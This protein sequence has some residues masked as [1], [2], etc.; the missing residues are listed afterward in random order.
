MLRSAK[1]TRPGRP[2]PRADPPRAGHDAS[3]YR[4]RL[5]RESTPHLGGV[6][7]RLRGPHVSRLAGR[8]PRRDEGPERDSTGRPRHPQRQRQDRQHQAGLRVRCDTDAGPRRP[9]CRLVDQDW[10]GMLPVAFVQ[11]APCPEVWTY[12]PKSVK[13]TRV[14]PPWGFGMRSDDEVRHVSGSLPPSPQGLTQ[15][16]R[17]HC[18]KHVGPMSIQT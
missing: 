7:V 15:N 3:H 4:C 2:L 12:R 17:A 10:P 1:D 11:R 16:F 13:S 5:A 14:P 6:P 18:W 9:R 8:W